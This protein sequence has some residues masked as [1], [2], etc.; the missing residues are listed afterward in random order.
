MTTRQQPVT[1]PLLGGLGNQL[2]QLAAGIAAGRRHSA[3]IVFSDYWL[4]NPAPGETR[5]SV[6]LSGL[7]REGELVADLVPRTVR[8]TDRITNRRVIERSAIDDPLARV[9][10]RTRAVAGYFQRLH[11]VKEAWPELRERLASSENPAHRVLTRV[12]TSDCGALHYRLGDYLTSATA[13]T[14]HGA[15][16]P[17]YFAELI[18]T[19]NSSHGIRKW[20]VVSDDPDTAVQLLTSVPL[21]AGTELSIPEPVDEWHD[22]AVLAAARMC[23][24]SNSSFSWWAAFIGMSAGARHVIA[25]RPWFSRPDQEEP[26]LFPSSWERRQRTLLNIPVKQA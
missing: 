16:S 14:H 10:S 6:A 4:R 18:R 25:P 3:R 12:S 8:V 24:I 23:A 9:D 26:A 19:A 15:T 5:R 17:E 22:L 20:H 11:Y 1:V 7:L 2:F 21:P 13:N